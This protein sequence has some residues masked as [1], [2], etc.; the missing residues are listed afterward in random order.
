LDLY[1][2]IALFGK[3]FGIGHMYIYTSLLRMTDTMT[4]Q[5]ID[6]SPGRLCIR[7]P[8]RRTTRRRRKRMR[9]RR[10]RTLKS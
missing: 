3:P 1:G 9:R 7:T 10:K 2:E 5:N 6:Y 8:R 4:S